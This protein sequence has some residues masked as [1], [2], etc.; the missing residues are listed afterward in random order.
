MKYQHEPTVD[1]F[2]AF[3]RAGARCREFD[4]AP[5][6][7]GTSRSATDNEMMLRDARVSGARPLQKSKSLSTPSADVIKSL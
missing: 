3:E 7:A 4:L 2:G 1:N 6:L 5:V